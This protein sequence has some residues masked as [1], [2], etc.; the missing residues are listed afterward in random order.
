MR[1]VLLALLGLVAGAWVGFE[2]RGEPVPEDPIRVIVTELKTQAVIEHERHIAVWYRACPEVTGVNPLMFVAWPAKLSYELPLDDV[3]ITRNG[4]ILSVRTAALRVD[5]PTVPT[6]TLDYVS[7]EPILNLVNEAELVSSEMKKASSVARYLSAYY[8]KRDETLYEDMTEQLRALIQRIGSAVDA[9]ITQVDVDI[10]RPDPKLPPV[11]ALELCD[12]T[13]AAVN[14][15]AF[16]KNES[17]HVVPVAF[18]TKMLESGAGV[19]K[20]AAAAVIYGVEEETRK[21]Q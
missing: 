4:T 3:A 13:L 20:P 15:L 5:E 9:G 21:K 6:D 8:L 17:G 11:P 10:P 18:Q 2:F 1:Y 19:A 14:G 12:G 16:A 7:T